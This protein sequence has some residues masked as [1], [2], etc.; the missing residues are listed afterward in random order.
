MPKIHAN[1]QAFQSVYINPT[2]EKWQDRIILHDPVFS[3]EISGV[4]ALKSYRLEDCLGFVLSA[5]VSR[6]RYFRD[7]VKKA[8]KKEEWGKL[9]PQVIMDRLVRLVDEIGGTITYM[10]NKKNGNPKENIDGV[11][12][13]HKYVPKKKKQGKSVNLLESETP[14][15]E[16]EVDATSRKIYSPAVKTYPEGLNE[17]GKLMWDKLLKENA[18]EIYSEEDTSDRWKKALYFFDKA[19]SSLNVSPYKV[20]ASTDTLVIKENM[21]RSIY[22][23][24]KEIQNIRAM[25]DNKR[26]LDRHYKL[27]IEDIRVYD[28]SVFVIGS[29][30]F[31][32]LAG[33][34]PTEALAGLENTL[35]FNRNTVKNIDDRTAI[36]LS[37]ENPYTVKGYLSY[38]LPREE[39][40]RLLGTDKSNQIKCGL[41]NAVKMMM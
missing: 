1:T 23:G 2:A 30:I 32:L 27:A 6:I 7:K 41:I 24:K 9:A 25:I 5:P 12:S 38:S 33:T 31:K 4:I 20:V 15:K 13:P 10:Q 35:S 28:D 16:K 3:D 39:V 17:S 11:K 22:E 37:Y 34:E 26:L 19:C 21:L 36:T 40:T 14:I 8:D 18:D 29:F